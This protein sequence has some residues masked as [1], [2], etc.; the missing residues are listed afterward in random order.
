VLIADR[1][2]IEEL[3]MGRGGMGAVHRGHDKHL[4]RR[5]AVKFLHVPGG[6]EAD[7]PADAALVHDR[8]TPFAVDLPALPGFLAPQP[9]P[10]ARY[11][12]I[13]SRTG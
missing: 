8:L 5:V 7:R 12:R 13:W 2:E 3:P 9:G 1:Y 6:S 10:A 4:D 11:A